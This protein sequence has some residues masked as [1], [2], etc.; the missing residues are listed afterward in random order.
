MMRR[1][2]ARTSLDDDR[3]QP[4]ERLVEEDDA[5][6]EDQRQGDCEHLL[7]AARKGFPALRRRSR[8]AR[9]KGE[10]R[11]TRPGPGLGHG[12]QVFLDGE[13]AEDAALLR[14]PAD[15]GGGALLGALDA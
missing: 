13:R 9:E 1:S 7:F 8:K 15:P 11:S 4:L 3:R 14:H 10:T 2:A 5:R 6:I 12:G